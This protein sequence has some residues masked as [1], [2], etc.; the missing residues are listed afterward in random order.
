MLS[1]ADQ[2]LLRAFK[3]QL[4]FFDV[5]GTLLN[6]QGQYS[7]G[8]KQQLL[9]LHTQGVKLAVA[10]GRPSI[11][12]QFLFDELPLHSAGCF[13]T[14]AELYNP[15]TQQHLQCHSLDKLAVAQLYQQVQRSGLYCE[16]YTPGYYTAM[17]SL[18]ESHRALTEIHSQHLRVKPR[19]QHAA[20]VLE[21]Q[22]PVLKLLLGANEQTHGKQLHTLVDDFPQF[23]FAFAHFLAYPG[24]LFA[25][26]VSSAADKNQGFTQLLDYHQVE[27]KHVMA[28]GDSHSDVMFL[29]NAGLGIAMGN[30]RDEIKTQADMATFAADDDG[31]ARTLAMLACD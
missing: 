31:V 15:Q 18:D 8:L 23:D 7:P 12:A 2:D 24:W 14:G 6:T 26:V 5:D 11:A 29:N 9:R 10:S 13:C 20:A 3:P 25:S 16:F 27:S 28:F 21:S 22:E 17:P 19:T 30:A 1:A 4:I